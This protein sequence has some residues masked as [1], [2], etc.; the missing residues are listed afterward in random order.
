MSNAHDIVEKLISEAPSPEASGGARNKT[1]SWGIYG[2]LVRYYLSGDKLSI[3]NFHPGQ[4]NSPQ[5]PPWAARCYSNGT[6]S[7][8]RFAC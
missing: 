2:I 3:A 8:Q 5:L 6:T 7:I 4:G 1:F